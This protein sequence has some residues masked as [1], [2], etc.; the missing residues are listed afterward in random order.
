MKIIYNIWDKFIGII[1]DIAAQ[2]GL[3]PKPI[4]ARVKKNNKKKK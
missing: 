1:D 2:F 3:Q 4:P